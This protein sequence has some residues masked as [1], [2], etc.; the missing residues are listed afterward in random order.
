MVDA[1]KANA[2]STTAVRRA[3]TFKVSNFKIPFVNV[4]VLSGEEVEKKNKKKKSEKKK[5]K[6]IEQV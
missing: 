1:L 6:V 5:G 3:R 4:V 2:R